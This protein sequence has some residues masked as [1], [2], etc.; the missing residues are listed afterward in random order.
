M[1][2][3]SQL[4]R[5]LILTAIIDC[6][7]SN[8]TNI[9]SILEVL[10]RVEMKLAVN[11]T[12]IYYF[13]ASRNLI[14]H[15]LQESLARLSVEEIIELSSNLCSSALKGSPIA[16]A[17]LKALNVSRTSGRNQPIK[18][19]FITDA[20]CTQCPLQD[21]KAVRNAEWKDTMMVVFTVDFV[22]LLGETYFLKRQTIEF[23]SALLKVDP[24][25][26]D[27]NKALAQ[28]RGELWID[29]KGLSGLKIRF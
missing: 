17:F 11:E 18:T 10:R 24:N 26:E 25:F 28:S 4:R 14:E 22:K 6:S 2:D 27:V 12:A 19:L 29:L 16:A 15:A 8:R 3:K 20:R 9:L 13:P 1:E 5:P 21:L 7:E 23:L